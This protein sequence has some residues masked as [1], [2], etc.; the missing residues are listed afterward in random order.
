MARRCEA[1][2]GKKADF[3]HYI[4]ELWRKIAYSP[5]EIETAALYDDHGE[6]VIEG[7]G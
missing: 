6:G 1:A 5:G 2:G 3:S 7:G 4:L